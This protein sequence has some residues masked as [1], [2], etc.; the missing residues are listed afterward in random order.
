MLGDPKRRRCH[1]AGGAVAEVEPFL[2]RRLGCASAITKAAEKHQNENQAGQV[3][4]AWS[5][6]ATSHGRSLQ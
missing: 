5:S 1:G 4:T 2:R 3:K 6:A